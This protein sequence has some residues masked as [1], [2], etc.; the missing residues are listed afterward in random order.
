[1]VSVL[2]LGGRRFVPLFS[3]SLSD[4]QIAQETAQY[5][6]PNWDSPYVGSFVSL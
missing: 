2:G 6:P 4:A 3:Q 1:M 5:S